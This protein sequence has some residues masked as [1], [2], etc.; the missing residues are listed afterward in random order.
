MDTFSDKLQAYID[1][2][3]IKIQTLAKLTLIE[4][5]YLHKIIS[6]DRTPDEE[7]LEKI[8][9]AL[10]MT[11]EQSSQLRQ[12][13]KIRKMGQSVYSRHMLVKNLIESMGKLPVSNS[14]IDFG[15]SHRIGDVQDPGMLYGTNE[16]QSMLKAVIEMEAA[17]PSGKIRII[18]QPEFSFLF[19]MLTILGRHQSDLRV[20]HI[21]CL[22]Q[23]V[24]E[25]DD[26]S[27]NISCLSA[28]SPL[29]ASMLNYNPVV[30]YD[31]VKSH[32]NNTSILPYIIMTESCVLNISYD[33]K[34]ALFFRS[35]PFM[36][37]YSSLYENIYN[38][39]KP[40]FSRLGSA[41]DYLGHYENTSAFSCNVTLFPEPCIGFFITKNKEMLNK[42]CLPDFPNRQ[43]IIT[44]Y[45]GLMEKRY[46]KY[47]EYNNIIESYFTVEGLDR[48]ISTGRVSELP[49][50]YYIP[51]EKADRYKLL[52]EMYTLS[53]KGLFFASIIDDRNFAVPKNIVVA[54]A[55]VPL[56]SSIVCIHPQAGPMAF[57]L[58]EQ[59]LVYSIAS[60][61]EYLKKSD[62]VLSTEKTM[63][64]FEDR[65]EKLKNELSAERK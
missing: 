65:L 4:R 27:Y 64:I 33:I 44:I 58:K 31:H 18:A 56:S 1:N 13:Y 3:G 29:L 37:F 40:M 55:M 63:E 20:E 10:M 59:S 49:D 46:K 61:L 57:D 9:S 60:F 5:T 21:M 35:E 53:K 6:G 43:E 28:V 25:K 14:A 51:I 54:S 45:S 36:E 22:Q 41:M 2:A 24:G 23:S 7:I 26:N 8:I 42:Y 11:P 47:S 50:D 32:I 30:Y 34:H 15:F 39:S 12:L 19:D 48:F 62:R 17:R 38:I 52:L 16:I